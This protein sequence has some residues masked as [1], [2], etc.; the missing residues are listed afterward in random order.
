MTFDL[1]S[2]LPSSRAQAVPSS[3]R[4]EGAGLAPQRRSRA[5]RDRPPAHDEDT[6]D[7]DAASGEE[8]C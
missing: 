5:P 8:R 3:G 6:M 7:Q 1:L 4:V 2:E